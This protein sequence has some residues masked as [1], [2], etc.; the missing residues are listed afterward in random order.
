MTPVEREMFF[1]LSKKF[2][3][4]KRA[5][6]LKSFKGQLWFLALLVGFLVFLLIVIRLV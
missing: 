2:K 4:E 1:E 6:E 5:K 3:A